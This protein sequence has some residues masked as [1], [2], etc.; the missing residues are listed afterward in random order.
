MCQTKTKPEFHSRLISSD[1]LCKQRRNSGYNDNA[2]VISEGSVFSEY[3]EQT[4]TPSRNSRSAQ[5]SVRSDYSEKSDTDYSERSEEDRSEVITSD[6]EEK[7]NSSTE[8][9][10]ESTW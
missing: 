8:T 10:E 1:S 3:T 4:G 6:K 9:T 2:S 7:K 5:S